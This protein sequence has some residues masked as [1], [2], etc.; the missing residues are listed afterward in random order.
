MKQMKKVSV[1][2]VFLTAVLVVIV[3]VI[4]TG[5]TAVPTLAAT[6]PPSQVASPNEAVSSSAAA[7]VSQTVPPAEVQSPDAGMANCRYGATPVNDANDTIPWLSTIGAGWFLTFG[8][9]KPGLTP[10]NDARFVPVLRVNEEMVGDTFTGVWTVAGQTGTAAKTYV[11]N[12][13]ASQPGALWIVGNEVDRLTQDEMTPGVYAQAYHNIYSWI[14]EADPTAQVAISGLVEVTPARLWYLDQVW[15]S[16]KS[17][18]GTIMP[19]DVWNMHLYIINEVM[20]DGTPGAA[21]IPIGFD[22]ASNPS[23]HLKRLSSLGPNAS[24]E[25]ADNDIYCY[26]EHDDMTIFAQQIHDMRTWMKAHGQQNKPL[27]LSEYSLLWPYVID[28]GGCFLQ[29]ER[30]KCF[31]PNRVSTFMVNSFNYLENAK[32]PNL[33]YSLD[34]NRLVQQWMWFS[35]YVPSEPEAIPAYPGSASNLLN[36]EYTALTQMGTTYR[37]YVTAQGVNRNLFVTQVRSSVAFTNGNPTTTATLSVFF[38]NN[39][40]TAVTTPFNV[41]FYSN[42]AMTNVIGTASFTPKVEGCAMVAYESLDV[43]WTNLAPGAHPFWVKIDS[44]AS[45]PE[46]NE[47]DNVGYGTV[48][49]D[50]A[51]QV[52]LPGILR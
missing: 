6:L 26:A 30:G 19:V 40:N 22:P 12:L 49:V 15:N 18:Y 39:G 46:T 51:A 17:L 11:Q 10:S 43:Q 50:P 13:V 24:Q 29:D 34:D 25:C 31:D 48:I 47:S 5:E 28:P 7:P 2:L 36:K 35:L 33:G 8:P 9:N 27:I 14:K 38:R 16:Y 20:F 1:A 44:S 45:I 4:T 32:D 3:A 41:T 37:N 21:H 42:A 52:F 23:I